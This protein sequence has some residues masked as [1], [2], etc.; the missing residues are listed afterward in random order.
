[1]TLFLTQYLR[2]LILTWELWPSNSKMRLRVPAFLAVVL[3]GPKFDSNHR[4]A[5]HSSVHPL[6]DFPNRILSGTFCKSF[7]HSCRKS[8]AL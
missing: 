5:I 2:K 7:N 4:N 3:D 1:M 8:I 6:G